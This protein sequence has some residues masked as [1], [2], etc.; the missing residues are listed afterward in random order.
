[1]EVMPKPSKEII[2]NFLVNNNISLDLDNYLFK[3]NT[4]G[5]KG[6]TWDKSRQKWQAQMNINNK[7]IFLGYF[8]DK[9]DAIIARTNYENKIKKRLFP[10]IDFGD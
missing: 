1:M 2:S 7:H 5:Y 9:S 4:S 3:N 6:V 8:K 10:S